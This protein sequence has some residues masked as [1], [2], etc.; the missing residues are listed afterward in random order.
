MSHYLGSPFVR[1]KAHA[2]LTILIKDREILSLSDIIDCID[3]A[4]DFAVSM[5]K[6]HNVMGT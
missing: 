5:A 2:W 6:S 4:F 3:I 1:S